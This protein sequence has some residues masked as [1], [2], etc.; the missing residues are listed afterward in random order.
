M[1]RATGSF[2]AQRASAVLLL[3]F[4]IWFM[5]SLV[6]HAGANPADMRAWL[7]EPVTAGVFAI[8]IAIS[9]FHM[10]IGLAE[11]IEDYIHSGAKGVL[12][13][14]NWLAAIAVGA[15]AIYSA[16]VLAFQG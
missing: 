4:V 12:M 10:R 6:A 9:A 13:T 8:F 5:W 1:N 7:A 16:Y 3:P 2:I 11:V 14:L 15:A